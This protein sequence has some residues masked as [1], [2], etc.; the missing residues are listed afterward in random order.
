[1][2][3]LIFALGFVGL[4]TAVIRLSTIP[5]SAVQSTAALRLCS[6]IDVLIAHLP[7]EGYR[8]NRD[9]SLP[10]WYLRTGSLFGASETAI[11]QRLHSLSAATAALADR[12]RQ[13]TPDA[14]DP[15]AEARRWLWGMKSR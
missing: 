6:L 1:M 14:A 12:E 8:F 15:Q 10:R 2:G 7:A 5:A 4:L 13:L 3:F 11:A 9:P